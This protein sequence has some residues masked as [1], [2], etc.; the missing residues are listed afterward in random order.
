MF[1]L[2]TKF[3]R[4]HSLIDITLDLLDKLTLPN[5][6]YLCTIWGNSKLKHIKIYILYQNFIRRLLKMGEN[7]SNCMF[8][9]KLGT[10]SSTTQNQRH[11]S[12]SGNTS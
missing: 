6:I 5:Q 4:L 9:G 11:A 1:S 3:R 7:I 10:R 2:N 8:Y 12:G